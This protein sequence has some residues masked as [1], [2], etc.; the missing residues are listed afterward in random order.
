MKLLDLFCGAGGCAVG[1]YRAGFHDI[2][3]I[4][5]NPQPRYP[6]HFIQADALEYLAEHG[7]EYDFIHASPP[8]QAYSGLRA[9]NIARWGSAPE[10]PDL[11]VPVREAL[12]ASG[13]PY[14]I[15]NVQNSPLE[16]QIILCGTSLGLPHTARHRHFE[17]S[18][19]M[20]GAPKCSHYRSEYTIGVYGDKPDGHR[21][22]PRGQRLSR[23]ASS[24]DEAG[25]LMGIDWMTWDEIRNAIPPVYTQW[26]G[27]QFMAMYLPPEFNVYGD[28]PLPDWCNE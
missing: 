8:C 23:T 14:V 4:D 2:T 13:K 15:E 22:S 6:Y 28:R 20:L 7:H 18:F 25:A 16:T 10:H 24:I 9:I 27:E 11:I 5:I 26:I 21:V 12:I 1:Y 3:G 17:S 19:L